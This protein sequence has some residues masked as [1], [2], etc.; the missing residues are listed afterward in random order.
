MS[1]GGAKWTAH[2]AWHRQQVMLIPFFPSPAWNSQEPYELG[3]GWFSPGYITKVKYEFLD[4]FKKKK[5]N[6]RAMY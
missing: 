4:Y 6:S 2:P 5:K 1:F 3:G